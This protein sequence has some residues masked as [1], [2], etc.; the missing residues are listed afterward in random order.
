MKKQC[1]KC[2]E[3]KEFSKFYKDSSK[4][5]GLR[6]Q[7]KKCF[8]EMMKEYYQEHK[9]ELNKKKKEYFQTLEG[10]YNSYKQGSKQ[11]NVQFS[12][13]FE[14]FAQFWQQPCGYC[15]DKIDTIGLDRIDSSK[16]YEI[17][18]VISCCWICND[19]KKAK[20]QKDFIEQCE[21]IIKNYKN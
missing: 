13:T 8:D 19:M 9:D 10:R 16:G 15:G 6:G 11:R 21:K 17:K 5:N 2:K 12:L 1:T 7:C 20:S 4:K 18:N 3:E 14:Q